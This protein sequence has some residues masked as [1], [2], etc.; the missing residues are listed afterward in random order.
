VQLRMEDVDID[1]MLEFQTTP[2]SE[3]VP[4]LKQS[5]AMRL[6]LPQLSQLANM[7]LTIHFIPAMSSEV[8]RV[9]SGSKLLISDGYNHLGDT[10]I[11]A[12]ECLKSWERA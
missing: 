7:A 5:W 4:D 2:E 9:F 3:D 11:S 1:Q 10:V 6:N 8:E 12:V